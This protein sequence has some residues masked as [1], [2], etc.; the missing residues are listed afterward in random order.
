L[1]CV[2]TALAILGAHYGVGRHVDDVP[3]A[4]RPIAS[5]WRW[6]ATLFYIAIAALL[7]LVVGFFLLRICS[8]QRWRRITIWVLMGAVS[9]FNIIYIFV[10][11]FACQ[12]TE[13]IW[14]RY[15]PPPNEGHGDCSTTLFVLIPTYVSAFLN[16]LA[17]WILPLLPATVVWKARMEMRKKISVCAVIALGSM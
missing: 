3:P 14:T 11:V 17:D 4:D 13:Y 8:N 7:K 16:V 2:Y 15:N 12:P 6:I 9:V 1:Y 5:M 10:A